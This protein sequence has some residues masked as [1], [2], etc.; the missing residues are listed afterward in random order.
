MIYV[1]SD[2]HGYSMDKFLMLLAKANFSNNDLLY[3]IGNVIDRNGDGGVAML[4]WLL[5]QPNAQLILGNHE[6]MLLACD[7]MFDE[8]TEEL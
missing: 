7:F 5:E 1:I 4:L 6:E 3:I 2:L 8:I